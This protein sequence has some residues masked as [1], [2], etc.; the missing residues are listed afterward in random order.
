LLRDGRCVL[1]VE[2]VRTENGYEWR[3]LPMEKIRELAD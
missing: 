2:E 1:L 3:T